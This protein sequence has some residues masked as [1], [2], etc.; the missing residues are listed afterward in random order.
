[1]L[2]VGVGFDTR[3][4]KTFVVKGPNLN[5]PP[6]LHVV[7]DSREGWTESVRRLLDSYF[8]KKPQQYF[9]YSQIREAGLPIKGFGGLTSGSS[10]LKELHT[11]I[12]YILDREI[13]KPISVSAIVD[14][15]NCI[16][17]CVQAASEVF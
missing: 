7:S 12:R 16:A 15:M 17:K 6:V 5:K 4:A 11:E 10:A 8:L 9:D 1:M 14:I 13:G 2:G 3:G